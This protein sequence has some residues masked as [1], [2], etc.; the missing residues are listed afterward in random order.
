M[1]WVK[2][3]H[4]RQPFEVKCECDPSCS[5]LF[6]FPNSTVFF[7]V[8]KKP[9]TFRINVS[10][11]K[12]GTAICYS[13]YDFL[14]LVHAVLKYKLQFFSQNPSFSFSTFSS[15]F[16]LFC[17]FLLLNIPFSFVKYIRKPAVNTGHRLFDKIKLNE[18][19]WAQSS[20]NTF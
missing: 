18:K 4:G 16:C 9:L 6:P 13:K 3:K 15:I 7:K 20:G 8:N 11:T 14:S 10:S 5:S 2:A 17:A 12:K 1:G 19:K